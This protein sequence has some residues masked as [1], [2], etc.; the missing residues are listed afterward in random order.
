MSTPFVGDILEIENLNVSGYPKPVITYQWLRDGDVV[1][2]AS[3]STYEV[4]FNDVGQVVSV[5][6]YATN[7][8]GVKIKTLGYEDTE[9]V[10]E[11]PYFVQQPYFDTTIPPKDPD[12]PNK[13]ILTAVSLGR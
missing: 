3:G 9:G 5:M 2:G 10:L 11:L 6:I 4:S 7:P 8:Y 13:Y 1:S 12:T